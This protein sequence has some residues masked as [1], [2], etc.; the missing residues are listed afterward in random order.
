MVFIGQSE[1]GLV[2]GALFLVVVRDKAVTGTG[3]PILGEEQL[4]SAALKVRLAPGAST[5][6]SAIT[7]LLKALSELQVVHGHFSDLDT[8]KGELERHDTG[9]R[10][11]F[12]GGTCLSKAHGLIQRMSEDIDLKVVLEP[13][14]VPLKK[15]RGQR[16]WLTTLHQQLTALLA[17]LQFPLL[18]PSANDGNPSIRDAH[19]YFVA[20]AGYQ[21]TYDQLPS[22]RP[23]LKL[24]V[25][26]PFLVQDRSQRNACICTRSE[27]CSF[28]CVSGQEF[29]SRQ[30]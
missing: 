3:T 25:P 5:S 26:R 21:S 12:A 2:D 24:E 17:Q 23:E 15:G 1:D 18:P 22:L 11:V 8:R 10:L 13:T 9:I 20:G 16:A 6:V 19:R 27:A 14:P 7:D 30:F 29:G 28:G 4:R